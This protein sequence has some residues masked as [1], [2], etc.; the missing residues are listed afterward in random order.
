M[1]IIL[2]ACVALAAVVLDL[3]PSPANPRNSEGD[4]VELKNGR[5]LYVYSHYTKGRGGDDDPAVL[6]SRESSD[7]GCTWTKES[8]P[9]VT[10]ACGQNVMSV[11]FFRLTD[12]RIGLLY[13]RN[14]A[15]GS[16][17][18]VLRTSEDETRTWAAPRTVYDGDGCL[19]VVNNSR[20][21][22]L[23]SGRLL[24]PVAR[25]G[26]KN[27]NP[28]AVAELLCLLSDD[29][30]A[31][32]TA[33]TEAPHA[34]WPDGSRIVTQ[35]PGVVELKDGRVMLWARTNAGAQWVAFSTDGG[36]SFGPLSA[37]DLKGPQGPATI[38]RLS[39]GELVAVWNDHAAEPDLWPRR[40]PLSIAVSRDEGLN[41]RNRQ[42]LESDPAGHYCYVAVHEEGDD[43]L[44]SY[45]VRDRR[46]LD[47]TRIVRLPVAQVLTAQD[48]NLK[49]MLRFAKEAELHSKP[50]DGEPLLAYGTGDSPPGAVR[51][52]VAAWAVFETLSQE[53]LPEAAQHAL[54]AE[55]L[56]RY[57]MRTYR[58]YG[59]YRCADQCAWEDLG[60][61][62]FAERFSKLEAKVAGGVMRQ[63][64][65]DYPSV[66]L[67]VRV[68]RGRY[69]RFLRD[70][71]RA[72]ASACV[73]RGVPYGRPGTDVRTGGFL[74]LVSPSAPSEGMVSGPDWTI[75]ATVSE[76]APLG[77]DEKPQA[78]LRRQARVRRIDVRTFL[79]RERVTALRD[80]ELPFGY[81]AIPF[82]KGFYN[83]LSGGEPA[84]DDAKE[85]QIGEVLYDVTYS[86]Q[87]DGN[88]GRLAQVPPEDLKLPVKT[89]AGDETE[90]WQAKIDAA[91]AAGGGRVVV[92]AGD[93][94]VAELELKNNVTLELTEGSR[95]LAVTNDVAYR[96]VPGLK[97][98]LQK[99]GVVVAY[100]ATNIA[101]VGKGMIDGRGNLQPLSSSR[102]V[103]WRNVYFEK[104]VGV[105]VEGLCLQNP[106]FWTCFLD[107]CDKVHIKGVS[108]RSHANYNNDGLDLCVSN[109]LVEECD[110]DSEDD[111]IVFKNFDSNWVSENVE[112]RN[113]R[114]SSCASFI[115]FGTETF[116][117]FR[118]YRIHH[119]E[120]V[121][122]SM[123]I[124][125]HPRW[126]TVWPGVAD[127]GLHGGAGLAFLIVDGGTM[128]NVLVQDI[129][130]RKGVCMPFFFRLGRRN[131]K[132]NWDRTFLRGVT[133]E[134]IRMVDVA[135]SAVG[136]CIC[137]VPGADVSDVVIRDS[138]FRTMAWPDAAKAMDRRFPEYENSYPSAAMFESAL[139][140]HFLYARHVR[141]IL[142]DNVT[143]EN[144]GKGERRPAVATDDVGGVR[145][146]KCN[147][148][149]WERKRR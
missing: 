126:T 85:L 58:A 54:T 139:P 78:V 18:V 12:G 75:D 66:P 136:S 41:W 104:C 117:P 43:L 140:G 1:N 63:E 144:V 146:E 81:R 33:G 91:S 67:A 46:N 61:F 72:Y 31:T 130:M 131:G 109:A 142:L 134:R 20:V 21:V 125:R 3:P 141:N 118:N 77:L 92:P 96:W 9:V 102:P 45:C 89:E 19:A 132:E 13:L 115:K 108:I 27:G 149:I 60:P 48:E 133:L 14:H 26:L 137:G 99:T 22:R 107:R 80:C 38:R 57:L 112:V 5:I 10:N 70:A 30:G 116:G 82:A 143:V 98:E 34:H 2:L 94:I 7:G 51:A 147:V 73:W 8:V 95:L 110:I 129:T 52:V 120:L 65:A 37:S 74:G 101:L 62:G 44:L 11:S 103:R 36:C 55:A 47:T 79:V 28:E 68:P 148:R 122:R 87:A 15:D 64:R 121:S 127:A 69:D 97:G 29:D 105:T 53:K 32:W 42:N 35:E 76:R 113:C 93:H 4:F 124:I 123:P 17:E 86:V 88:R 90:L 106:S 138:T 56:G 119:C 40:T 71:E 39:S 83:P 24:V 111:A 145:A 6:A 23:A 16:N 135:D 25:H 100:C 128:E 59:N 50:T 49:E 84:Q 114:V